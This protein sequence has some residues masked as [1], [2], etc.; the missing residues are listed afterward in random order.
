VNVWIEVGLS[1]QYA[2]K[3]NVT[4][5]RRGEMEWWIVAILAIAVVILISIYRISLRE[6]RE[7]THYLLMLI[8][9]DDLYRAARINLSNFVA[10]ADANNATQLNTQV[11][12]AAA[13][14]A[15]NMEKH[16]LV[17]QRLLWQMKI[18]K[19]KLHIPPPTANTPECYR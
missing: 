7:L 16:S 1:Q 12:V 5:G 2:L 9:Q 17:V 4:F 10:S 19:L 14:S 15:A 11:F 8:L 6:G 3:S 13:K 18:G